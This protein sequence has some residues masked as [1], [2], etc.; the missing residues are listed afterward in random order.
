MKRSAAEQNRDDFCK[1]LQAEA[2]TR[3]Q[4]IEKL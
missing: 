3:P 2:R 4:A 1:T